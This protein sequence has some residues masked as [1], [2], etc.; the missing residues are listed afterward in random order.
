MHYIVIIQG[1]GIS[2]SRDFCEIITK[3]MS[4]IKRLVLRFRASH[5]LR[6]DC[7]DRQQTSGHHALVTNG[8]SGRLL[9]WPTPHLCAL[10]ALSLWQAITDG[11]TDFN[12]RLVAVSH[13]RKHRT[14]HSHTHIVTAVTTY[15]AFDFQDSSSARSSTFLP[16][17]R[18]T[19]LLKLLASRKQCH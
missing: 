18:F 4:L 17:Q 13:T 2:S 10:H 14:G 9:V 15:A 19:P 5:E 7:F 6:E 3:V 12:Y 8:D 1:Y 11:Q 16:F